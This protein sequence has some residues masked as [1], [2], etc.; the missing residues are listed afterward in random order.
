MNSQVLPNG[1]MIGVKYSQENEAQQQQTF[2]PAYIEEWY[3]N[4][5]ITRRPRRLNNFW[6]NF[7]AYVLNWE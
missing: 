7:L 4:Q 3:H 2:Q 1:E 6:E 5:N